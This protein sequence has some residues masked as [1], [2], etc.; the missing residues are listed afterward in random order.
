VGFFVFIAL[1]Q[2]VRI[3]DSWNFRETIRRARPSKTG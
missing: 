2:G 1:P 3:V